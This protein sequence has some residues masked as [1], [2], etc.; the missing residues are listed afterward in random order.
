MKQDSIQKFSDQGIPYNY[1]NINRYGMI[2]KTVQENGPVFYIFF[3]ANKPIL[4]KYFDV[5]QFGSE[6]EFILPEIKN[7]DENTLGLLE[8]NT[9]DVFNFPKLINTIKFKVPVHEHFQA[10]TENNETYL[11]DF[12][13]DNVEF[14]NHVVLN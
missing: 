6:D 7:L 3:K 13:K 8:V 10:E 4:M 14:Y 11:L 12:F 9:I 1:K 5:Y 2:Y